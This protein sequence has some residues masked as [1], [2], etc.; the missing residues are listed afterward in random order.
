MK[1]AIL[2]SRLPP[3][4]SPND[5]VEMGLLGH[6]DAKIIE[7]RASVDTG[8]P[9]S[10]SRLDGGSVVLSCRSTGAIERQFKI[11]IR[12]GTL[13]DAILAIIMAVER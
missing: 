8:Q 9:R 10:A 3:P 4:R 6:G 1:R 7:W 5:R 2:T 11:F 13:Q 12:Y